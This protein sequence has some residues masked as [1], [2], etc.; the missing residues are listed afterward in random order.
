MEGLLDLFEWEIET[1]EFMHY[2]TPWEKEMLEWHPEII[3]EECEMN[4]Q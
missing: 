3:P 4:K 1:V 2:R